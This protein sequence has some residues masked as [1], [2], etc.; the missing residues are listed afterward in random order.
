M[1]KNSWLVMPLLAL[2]L[3]FAGTL[4]A[5][6]SD[7]PDVI[8]LNPSLWAKHTKSPVEFSHK[9]HHD[10]YGVACT[11]CHHKYEGGQNVWKEGDPVKKCEECHNEPT[12]RGEKRLA[13]EQQKLNLKLA[14]HNNCIKCHRKV[15]KENRK[16]KAPTT[17]SKCHPRKKK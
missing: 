13:P 15:K 16:T 1:K 17:C 2:A 11:E 14:F 7:A 10:E 3:I 9:K 8:T 5:V 12:I 6:A 4:I